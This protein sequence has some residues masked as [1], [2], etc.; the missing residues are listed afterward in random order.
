MTVDLVK[1]RTLAETATPGPWSVADGGIRT[2]QTAMH[3][4]AWTMGIPEAAFIAAADP[5]TVL[6]LIAEIE[7]LEKLKHPMF[8]INADGTIKYTPTAFGDARAE[9]ARLDAL[10]RATADDPEDIVPCLPCGRV[11]CECGDA[12]GEEADS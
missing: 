4:V 10:S 1:L 9:I 5:S 3:T 12:V 11:V 6:A 8:E 7:R 2:V